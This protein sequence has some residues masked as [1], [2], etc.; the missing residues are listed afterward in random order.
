MVHTQQ[1]I[2][3][4][5]AKIDIVDC[6]IFQRSI[7]ILG[8]IEMFQQVYAG[9][10]VWLVLSVKLRSPMQPQLLIEFLEQQKQDKAMMKLTR[11]C[12]LLIAL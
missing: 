9:I 8:I 4:R 12:L 3:G 10:C 7:Y 6:Y 11:K 5:H 1:A 2:R